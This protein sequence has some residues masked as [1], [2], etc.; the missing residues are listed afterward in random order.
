M[1]AELKQRLKDTDEVYYPGERG[2][3]NE[4]ETM[5]RGTI[6]IPRDVLTKLKEMAGA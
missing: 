4:E 3:C 2:S 1:I 5:R 6:P